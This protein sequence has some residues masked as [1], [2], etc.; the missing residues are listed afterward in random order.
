LI[1]YVLSK[2]GIEENSSHEELLQRFSPIA[3][4]ALKQ[5]SIEKAGEDFIKDVESWLEV[6][7]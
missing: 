2:G 1:G 4:L 6:E 7:K 5:M 3:I